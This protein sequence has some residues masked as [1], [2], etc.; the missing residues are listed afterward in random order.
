[1]VRLPL[2]GRSQRLKIFRCG[3]VWEFPLGGLA[4]YSPQN[5]A[6]LSPVPDGKAT[7]KVEGS[8]VQPEGMS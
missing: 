8:A 3:F 6:A 1:M 2:K 7:E 5:F 4:D